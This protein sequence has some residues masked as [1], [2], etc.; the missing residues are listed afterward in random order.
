MQQCNSLFNSLNTFLKMEKNWGQLNCSFGRHTHGLFRKKKK[1]KVKMKVF[2]QLWNWGHCLH[3]VSRNFTIVFYC[4]GKHIQPPLLFIPHLWRAFKIKK[5]KK[6]LVEEK[7]GS[8]CVCTSTRP[9]GFC[10][11]WDWGL[12]LYKNVMW[13]GFFLRCWSWHQMGSVG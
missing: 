7:L 5:E 13:L 3:S 6:A 9:D 4:S 10:L 11:S 2:T 1:K 8:F 12:Y